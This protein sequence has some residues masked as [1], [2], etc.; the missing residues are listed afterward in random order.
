MTYSFTKEKV[1]QLNGLIRGHAEH[2]TELHV[3]VITFTTLSSSPS[4]VS[5]SVRG[6]W[7]T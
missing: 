1:E 5:T 4:S 2:L 6:V 3:S 7:F